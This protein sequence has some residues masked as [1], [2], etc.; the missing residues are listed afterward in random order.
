MV[1][2]YG[3]QII[4]PYYGC[5]IFIIKKIFWWD[6]HLLISKQ[7]HVWSSNKTCE[8]LIWTWYHNSIWN[9]CCIFNNVR[10][11]H[12]QIWDTCTYCSCS[13]WSSIYL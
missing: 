6:V 10:E 8:G 7:S 9:I 11:K 1:Y 3:I 12:G 2:M 5:Q 4:M 13:H